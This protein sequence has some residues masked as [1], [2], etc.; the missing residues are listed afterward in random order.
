MAPEEFQK[1]MASRV[2]DGSVAFVQH[3]I[4]GYKC[5]NDA[6]NGPLPL[7]IFTKHVGMTNRRT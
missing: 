4:T 7:M 1:G 6:K 5:S 3:T 2:E